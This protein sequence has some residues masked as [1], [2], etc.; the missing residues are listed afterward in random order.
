MR[1][2]IKRK[3]NDQHFQFLFLFELV[4]RSLTGK[5]IKT[6]VTQQAFA[7]TIIIIVRAMFFFNIRNQ[8]IFFYKLKFE[9]QKFETF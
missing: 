7:V 3:G 9:K 2:K 5:Y 6:S 8:S 4:Y 1:Q